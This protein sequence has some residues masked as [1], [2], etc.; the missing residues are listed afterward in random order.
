MLKKHITTKIRILAYFIILFVLPA[1]QLRSELVVYP[2]PVNFPENKTWSVQVRENEKDWQE[3]FVHNVTLVGEP[4]N[5]GSTDNWHIPSSMVHFSFSGTIEMRVT[6]NEGTLN[7]SEIRPASFGIEPVQNGNTLT[8]FVTQ[9][10]TFPRKFVL[11]A[12]DD[13]AALCL[14]VI[15]NPLEIN[16]PSREDVTHYFS[17]GYY[18]R[19]Q[20]SVLHSLKSG[21]SVYIAGGAVVEAGIFAENISDVWIGGRG[22]I[23]IREDNVDD[24]VVRLINC[25][26]FVIDGITAIAEVNGWGVRLIKCDNITV[27]NLS[28]FGYKEGSDGIHFDASQHCLATGCFIRSSDDLMLANGIEDG[29]ENCTDNIFKN[30]VLWGDKAHILVAG[31]SGNPDSSN[32]TENILYHNIDIINHKEGSP[33]FRGAIKIWCTNNQTVRNITFSDIRI[34]SFQNPSKARVLHIQLAPN[35]AYNQEGKAIRNVT[36]RNLS[37][38]G[39]GELP[40]LIFGQSETRSI[41]SMRIVNYTRNN[42]LVKDAASGNIDIG[43]HVNNIRFVKD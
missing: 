11:R 10:D 28:L 34:M 31:F 43:K 19:E 5:P 26:N 13:W 29:E 15:G 24:R 32:I 38:T 1:M 16:P 9:N 25:S 27:S 40:S 20:R 35:Y 30:S 14:H 23:Y 4:N 36:I 8:F 22:L 39:E 21:D 18:G 17:P 3:L 2:A 41:D 42:V 33:G 37:Y 12:N 7:T 6:L